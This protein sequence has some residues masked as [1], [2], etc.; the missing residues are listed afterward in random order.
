MVISGFLQVFLSG[1][2]GGVL[3]EL[4]KWYQL[5]EAVTLP[6]Y[7]HHW[8]YWAL[9]LLMVLAGGLIATL[10]GTEAKNPLLA[11][12]IGLSAPLIVKVLAE[13]RVSAAS[14][15]AE[16]VPP[17]YSMGTRGK[18]EASLLNFLAGR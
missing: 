17:G 15:P 18:T 9:T 7:A 12:H 16:P 11:L 13:T 10:Y 2:L 3:A 1:C 4:L 6:V 14:L 8:R 5:R